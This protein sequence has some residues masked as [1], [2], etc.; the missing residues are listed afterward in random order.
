MDDPAVFMDF[1]RNSLGFTTMRKI[2]LT[3][4]SVKSFGYLLAVNNGDIDTFV[5][6][7]HSVND[8]R[9]AVQIVLI[10]NKVT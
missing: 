4:K 9:A 5:K 1:V 6:Y 2:G 7:T 10:N 8:A 3:K